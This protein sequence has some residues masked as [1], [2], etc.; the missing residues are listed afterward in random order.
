[1]KCY[2]CL[3]RSDYFFTK[4]GYPLFRCPACGL[5][6]TDLG[7]PYS[8]FLKEFYTEGYYTGEDGAGA[9]YDYAKDKPNIVKN[10]RVIL[11]RIKNVKPHGTLLDVGCAYGYF[12]EL[13]LENGF[14]AYGFDPS[15]HAISQASHA[16][17]TRVQCCSVS[18][19]R[20]KKATFDSI[21]MLD[22]IEHLADPIADLKRLHRVLKEDGIV[23]ISTGDANSQVAKI[24]GRRWT[25]YI[26]PQH[27]FFFNRQTLT[28]LL[29]QSGFA[30]VAFYRIGKWVSL[31]YVLHLAKTSGESR[32]ASYVQ[33]IVE[34]L[35]LG[36]IPLY[37][38]MGDNM[39]VVAKKRDR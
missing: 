10:M 7:K 9:Y 27:L 29:E 25:F 19:T 24:L 3:K 6:Q 23:L 8:Q 21:S 2:L 39:V 13:A 22:I 38:P 28:D 30:P 35:R 17:R 4:N 1:M 12:V 26:P 34:T 14:D 31:S 5:I 32:I 16:I 20:Y 18:E 37:L 36:S 33:T 15:T 11:D